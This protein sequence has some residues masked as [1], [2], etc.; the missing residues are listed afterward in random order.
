MEN[1]E[2]VGA[3]AGLIGLVVQCVVFIVSYGIGG[4]IQGKLFE[5]AGKPMWIGWVPVYNVVTMLELVGRPI[6]WIVLWRDPLRSQEQESS[7]N[8]ELQLVRIPLFQIPT[9]HRVSRVQII[10]AR[11]TSTGE[12]KLLSGRIKTAPGAFSK[13]TNGGF[14]QE[15]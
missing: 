6:W 13:S 7:L 14:E 1:D 10:L 5:K 9:L 12:Y 4:F 15:H 11:F 3:A 8:V 2:A